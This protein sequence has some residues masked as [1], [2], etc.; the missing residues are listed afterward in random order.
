MVGFAGG[1]V[2]RGGRSETVMML[3]VKQ[4]RARSSAGMV[5]SMLLAC[6]SF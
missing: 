1:G 5:S 2:Q 6:W 3:R 4:A